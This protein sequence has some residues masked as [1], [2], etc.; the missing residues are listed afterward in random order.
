[1]IFKQK[2]KFS[3]R[4]RQPGPARAQPA[5]QNNVHLAPTYGIE[6]LKDNSVPTQL[7]SD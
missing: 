6:G 2:I 3:N 4:Q 7:T 5:L 1:M